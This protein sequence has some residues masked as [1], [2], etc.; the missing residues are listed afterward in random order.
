M[1]FGVKHTRFVVNID[2]GATLGVKQIRFGLAA[3]VV[4][5]DHMGVRIRAI[6]QAFDAVNQVWRSPSGG[7]LLEGRL[8]G[9]GDGREIFG[10][11]ARCALIGNDKR[12]GQTVNQR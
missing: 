3:V 6:R 8:H 12:R 5:P 2:V 11:V 4:N 9:L 1:T 7:Q 10:V